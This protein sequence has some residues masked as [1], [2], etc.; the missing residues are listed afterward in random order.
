[1][2]KCLTSLATKEIIIKTILKFHL[3][4]FRMAIVKPNHP[5]KQKNHAHKQTNQPD[6]LWRAMLWPFRDA[7]CYNKT[8]LKTGKNVYTL[9]LV[10][11]SKMTWGL[12]VWLK[13]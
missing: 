1:M 13:R 7:V 6:M 8:N 2:E 11:K 10:K 9:L 4:P 12:E 5:N 3:I